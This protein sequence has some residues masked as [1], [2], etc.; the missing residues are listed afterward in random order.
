MPARPEPESKHVRL[1][2]SYT[3]SLAKVVE[4]KEAQVS[5]LRVLAAFGLFLLF[6][7]R[8]TT[9]EASGEGFLKTLQM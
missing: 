4:F 1:R 8:W 2:E 6:R 3:T 5:E 9:S 7:K